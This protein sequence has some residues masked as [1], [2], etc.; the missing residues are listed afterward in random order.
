MTLEDMLN[1]V[2]NVLRLRDEHIIDISRMNQNRNI[3]VYST[4]YEY[5][6]KWQESPFYAAGKIV[7]GKNGIGIT[8]S[9]SVVS[10][11]CLDPKNAFRKTLLFQWE[12]SGIYY[13][14]L[15]M[16]TDKAKIYTQKTGERVMVI[17]VTDLQRW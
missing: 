16:F 14:M 8:V 9:H 3:I 17:L 13:T 6:L 11:W 7:F 2:C 4:K 12:G 10:N 5:L 1:E 15:E